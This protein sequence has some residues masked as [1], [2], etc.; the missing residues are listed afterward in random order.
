MTRAYA[1]TTQKKKKQ[2]TSHEMS[3]LRQRKNLDSCNIWYGSIHISSGRLYFLF[4]FWNKL[5]HR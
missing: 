5:L 3:M 2:G 4:H 1:H